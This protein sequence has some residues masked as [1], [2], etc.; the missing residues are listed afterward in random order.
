M[1]FVWISEQTDVFSMDFRTNGCVLYG[2]QNKQMCFVW[3]SEQTDVFS[4][5][6]V[7]RLVFI[8]KKA[9]CVYCAVRNKSLI[10]I[11]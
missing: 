2:F 4:Q 1:C 11:Y 7:N 6:N 8:K 3:I 10:K 5:Y 9:E